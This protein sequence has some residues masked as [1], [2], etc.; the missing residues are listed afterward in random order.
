MWVAQ[1]FASMQVKEGG[2]QMNHA[3]AD[4]TSKI[5]TPTV[6][7]GGQVYGPG[8]FQGSCTDNHATNAMTKL[9]TLFGVDESALAQ[10]TWTFWD[11][12]G[13]SHHPDD[14]NGQVMDSDGTNKMG[15]GGWRIPVG[16]YC[17]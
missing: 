7:V 4:K 1:Q 9:I 15:T 16:S 10:P 12:N 3:D 5:A 17:S 8:D 2:W 6:A 13:P 14:P 11:A